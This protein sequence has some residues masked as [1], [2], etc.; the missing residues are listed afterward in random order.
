M[1]EYFQEWWGYPV[2]I[3]E[4]RC[5]DKLFF[6]DLINSIAIIINTDSNFFNK[7]LAIF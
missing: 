5:K 2:F 3:K 4:G 7:I 1:T 6:Y